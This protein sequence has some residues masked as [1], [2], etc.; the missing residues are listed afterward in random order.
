MGTP[1]GKDEQHRLRRTLSRSF[2][3][4]VV[5][6]GVIVTAPAESVPAHLL[7]I[8]RS[9]ETGGDAPRQGAHLQP[10]RGK[11]RDPVDRPR[12]TGNYASLLVVDGAILALT[13][14]A[15]LIVLSDNGKSYDELARYAVAESPT[16]AHLVPVD[17]GVLVKDQDHLAFW[18][19]VAGQ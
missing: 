18:G 6:V 11:W 1:L 2:T 8:K 19:W 7:S 16:W 17:G 9:S 13:G 3:L 10:G 15:E 14:S 4:A 5:I 12:R